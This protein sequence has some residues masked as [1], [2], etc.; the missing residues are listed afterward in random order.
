MSEWVAHLI[1]L[2]VMDCLLGCPQPLLPIAIEN[3]QQHLTTFTK[4][5]Q[6][7]KMDEGIMKGNRCSRL[8]H[9]GVQVG[10]KAFFF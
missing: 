5:N 2:P 4:N 10:K 3:R 8:I 7:R 1:C 6:I 9:F